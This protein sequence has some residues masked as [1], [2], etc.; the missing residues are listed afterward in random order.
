[1]FF[2]PF[3]VE[4]YSIHYT[5]GTTEPL[6]SDQVTITN[7]GNDITFS[8]LSKATGNATVNVTMKKMGITS[9]TKVFS[10]SQQLEVTRSSGIST[11]TSNLVGDSRY[12]LRVED[13]E[14]S[15]NTP[16]VVNV[17][18]IYESKNTG[19]PYIK[20]KINKNAIRV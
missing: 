18:G 9:K 16:D 14:I 3:D 20:K 15:L 12:G 8:G 5:D 11:E 7:S 17:V 10:R 13:E 6:T 19:T 4:R 2:E 1:M